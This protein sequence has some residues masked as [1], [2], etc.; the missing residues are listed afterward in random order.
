MIILLFFLLIIDFSIPFFYTLRDMTIFDAIILGIVEGITEYL[1]IS[2]TGHLLIT[3]FLLGLKNGDAD[4]AF[5]VCIQ[6]GAILAVLGLYFSRV[7][8]M[9]RGLLGK[10]A[11]GLRLVWNLLAAFIPAVIIGLSCGGLIKEYLFGVWPIVTA[12]IIGGIAILLYVQHQK[13]LGKDQSGQ[14]LEELTLKQSF[15]IGLLQCVAMWPGTSRSLMTMLGGLFV[16]LS[17][18]AAVEFSFLLGL[19]T[20]SAATVYDAYKYGD[21]MLQEFGILPLITGTIVAWISAVLAIKWLVGY[22][23]R[24]NLNIFGWY[25]IGAGIVLA[26]MI[27]Y[28]GMSTH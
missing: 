22:L 3:Q 20:L 10:D 19:I 17:L 28:F 7:K 24:H 13:K 16:G 1:P 27:L 9:V 8:S 18:I 23:Q 14:S 4:K 11:V 12:W 25:R 26:S 2:S 6:G 15:I 5:A 21:V